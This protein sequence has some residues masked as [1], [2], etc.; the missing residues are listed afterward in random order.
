MDKTILF[1]GHTIHY[2]SELQAKAEKLNVVEYLKEIGE[3][4]AKV[5]FYESRIDEINKF[6]NE[7]N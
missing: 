6:K 2:W 5:N 4:R 7:Y 3:L 1:M